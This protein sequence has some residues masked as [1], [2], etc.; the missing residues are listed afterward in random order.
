M[1]ISTRLVLVL[2]LIVGALMAAA[3]F[4]SLRQHERALETAMRD[5]ARALA[6][7]L[8][9]ALEEEY[10]DGETEDAQRLIDRLRANTRTYGALLF[11]ASGRLLMLSDSLTAEELRRP[12]ELAR[13][14]EAGEAAEF[15]RAAGGQKVFS[16]ILPI[17]VGGERRGAVEVVHPLA[18]V[19]ADIARARLNQVATTLLL[20]ST[21]FAVVFAVLRRSL[22]QP[23]GELL[24]GAAAVGRGDLDYRVIVP[25]SGGEF[26]Q[27]AR[28]FNR[29]ADG[30]AEQRRA[31]LREAEE[32]L[33]LERDLRHSERLAAVGRLA[34]GVA[35]EMGAPLNVIDARAEQLLQRPDAPP[36]TRARNLTIIRAQAERITHIVRQL[37][38]LARGYDLRPSALDLREVTA[39]TLGQFEANAARAGVSVEFER[40]ESAAVVEADEEYVRRVLLSVFENAVQAMPSGGR[41]RVAVEAE[42]GERGGRRLASVSVTDT[43]QGIAPEDL[44][45]IFDPFYTTKEVGQGTGLGLSVA[46]RIVEEHGGVIE[47]ANN[48]EGG[49][50]FTIL[51]P[52]HEA[53]TAAVERAGGVER[54]SAAGEERA[55]GGAT[56]SR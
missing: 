29:M 47:A 55:R 32:R 24:G 34:A 14:L 53:A 36:E 21:I 25:R 18:F 15:V 33:R 9:I 4:L 28:E 22:T 3:S 40:G 17:E 20:L 6:V 11:D 51:L 49:A 39:D 44:T 52:L 19:E 56:V 50:T 5:E 16:V 27:L 8:Q 37:L 23:V 46:R 41:L 43:G 35:H 26:A 12:P 54:R 2:T 31:A 7:T 42:G 38:N 45:K 13:V 48:A 10:A 1:S 30:L